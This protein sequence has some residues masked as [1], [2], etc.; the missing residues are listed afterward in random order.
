MLSTTRVSNAA[1]VN[2]SKASEDASPV[3]KQA[4]RPSARSFLAPPALRA[5]ADT[6]LL[7]LDKKLSTWAQKNLDPAHQESLA[8]DSVPNQ[9]ARIKAL[10][11]FLETSPIERTLGPV[12]EDSNSFAHRSPQLQQDI[13]AWVGNNP[14]RNALLACS[15]LDRGCR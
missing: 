4:E 6:S 8:A 15:P 13:A 1:P 14:V 10:A 9:A 7:K 2:G 5:R 3:A 12:S 11:A